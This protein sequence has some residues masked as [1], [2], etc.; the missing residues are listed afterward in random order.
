MAGFY[1]LGDSRALLVEAGLSAALAPYALDER[2]VL[3][4]GHD[5]RPPSPKVELSIPGPSI[6]YAMERTQNQKRSLGDALSL[7][8]SCL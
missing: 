4:G 6:A 7:L 1:S 5:Q 2:S 8:I 3:F